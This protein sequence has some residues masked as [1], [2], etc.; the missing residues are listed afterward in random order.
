MA[1]KILLLFFTFVSAYPSI[2]LAFHCT[3][4]STGA[5]IPIG[6]GSAN[7]YV[8]IEPASNGEAVLAYDLSQDIQCGNDK[9]GKRQS[10]I[11]YLNS[12]QNHIP[13]PTMSFSII[14]G[15][16][17]NIPY[18]GS[19][20]HLV[21]WDNIDGTQITTQYIPVKL[22]ISLTSDPTNPVPVHKNDLLYD[23]TFEQIAVPGPPDPD[24]DNST[25]YT[26][27]WHIYAANDA[28]IIPTT[29]EI[30]GNQVVNVDYGMVQATDIGTTKD[31]TPVKVTKN[32][33]VK[34]DSAYTGDINIAFM[35]TEASGFDSPDVLITSD[36][37]LGVV[38]T[39]S[40]K[41]I[42]LNSAAGAVIS[43]LNGSGS[44]DVGF[45]LVKKSSSATLA[46]GQF[47]ASAVMLI[48]IN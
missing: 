13:A 23:L 1:K 5:S 27:T 37:N 40:D 39:S 26:Y 3:V 19:N 35:G 33:D 29:C 44:T 34:C 10:D 48:T 11:L 9:T 17:Y 2:S 6:G 21:D 22:Y 36:S 25:K 14:N 16:Q 15:N 18:S 47:Q 28:I 45:N 7:V 20:I 4:M 8:N 43:L 12:I 30:N 41:N 31:N 42:P 38:L 24:G 46:G 32:I